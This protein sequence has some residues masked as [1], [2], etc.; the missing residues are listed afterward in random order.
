MAIPNYF[1]QSPGL[2]ALYNEGMAAKVPPMVL[3]SLAGQFMG[4]SRGDPTAVG[5]NGN[6]FGMGQ[7]ND[8]GPVMKSFA[9][10]MGKDW[11]DPTAQARFT[12]SELNGSEKK[13]YQ[14]MLAAKTPEE[15]ARAGL[16]YERPAGYNQP[17]FATHPTLGWDTRL[18]ETKRAFDSLNGIN[19]S[20]P[21]MAYAMGGQRG[22]QDAAGNAIQNTF[23]NPGAQEA[24]TQSAMVNGPTEKT[25]WETMDNV[26]NGLQQAGA[27]LMA[28]SNPGGASVLANM[29]GQRPRNAW[30]YRGQTANGMGMIMMGPNGETRIDPLP[31]GF[32]GQSSSSLPSD[33]R[34]FEYAKTHPEYA[35]YTQEKFNREH[36][37]DAAPDPDSLKMFGMDYLVNGNQAALKDVPQKQRSEAL[38]LAKEQF[39]NDTGS[40]YDPADLAIRRGAYQELITESR[41]FGQMLAPT[42]TA[43]DRLLADIKIAKERVADLPSELNTHNLPWNQFMQMS[44]KALQDSGFAKLAQAREAIYN[45]ERGYSS[46]Q[47]SGMRAGDTVASQKRAEELINSAM[48]P[49]VLL[50]TAG[51]DGNRSGGLLDFMGDSA[52]RILDNV[53]GGQKRLREEWKKGAQEFGSGLSKNEAE[54]TNEI[55][56]RIKPQ[57]QPQAQ[58]DDRQRAIEELRRRGVKF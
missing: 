17:D 44:S 6:A 20:G 52:N 28:I 40:D 51:K 14:A 1:A 11:R 42:Q 56:S 32:A 38:R 7:W 33:V 23:G 39:K 5:D 19:T 18:S 55:D 10:N 31:P 50:G 57:G 22:P 16:L 24:P 21:P 27:S 8:R 46:V 2:Q 25:G 58:P 49:D 48:T 12:F 53:K 9:Q 3:A 34:E 54:I 4:E 26:G 41:K 45:V 15:A 29:S 36:P 43:H 30:T 37:Q 35:Q 47:A 13:A